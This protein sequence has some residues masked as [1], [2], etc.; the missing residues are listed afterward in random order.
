MDNGIV[1]VLSGSYLSK[2]YAV[3]SNGVQTD[4]LQEPFVAYG[5]VDIYS[6]PQL[7]A[8]AY[9]DYITLDL[10]RWTLPFDTLDP[11][12]AMVNYQKSL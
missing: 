2:V 10:S 3:D 4:L 6:I 1:R 5:Q 11:V 8:V 7:A 9:D 12:P